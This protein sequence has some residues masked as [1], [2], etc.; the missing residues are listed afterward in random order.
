MKQTRFLILFVLIL[1][2]PMGRAAAQDEAVTVLSDNLT[3]DFPSEVT[4][5]LSFESETTIETIN[6]YY[7]TER[8]TCT[9]QARVRV[10]FDPANSGDVTWDWDL[11]DSGDL[12]PGAVI[13]WHWLLTDVDGNQF[14]T[15]EQTY[16]YEDPNYDWQ[17]ISQ[18]D[19]TILW[20]EGGTDFAWAM[21]R[22][23]MAAI[24]RL[25]ENAGIGPD[26]PVRLTVYPSSDAMVE[27]SVHMPEWAGGVAYT[28]YNLIVAGIQPTSYSWAEEV[29]AHEMGHLVSHTLVFNCVGTR[30]PTWLDEGISVYTEGPIKD[31][32][33]QLVTR[34]LES[35][36]LPTLRSLARGFAADAE[37][38]HLSYAQSGMVVNYM[39]QTFGQEK[40]A[41]LLTAIRDGNKIDAA[42]ALVYGLNTEGLDSEFRIAQGFDPLPGYDPN[43][44]PTP[45]AK[46]TAVPTLALVSPLEGGEAEEDQPAAEPTP[47]ATQVEPTPTRREPAQPTPKPTEAHETPAPRLSNLILIGIILAAG[48]AALAV[49]IIVIVILSRKKKK[50]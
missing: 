2:L 6:L 9:G 1:L 23:M 42:L 20:A 22:L 48:L 38:A 32:D 39:I 4:F 18:D 33:I 43:A 24:E 15:E 47:T 50:Q 29:I 27:A 5:A 30:M 8:R 28:D 40:F 41:Q 11:G 34:K 16:H 19:V 12:P 31:S 35:D 45:K 7:G 49:I 10:D 36:D 13:H 14:E 37:A 26:G 46:D 25:Q 17:S 21:H 44:T 3:L